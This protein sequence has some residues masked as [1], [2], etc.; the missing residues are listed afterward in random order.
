[1][2][3]IKKRFKIELDPNPEPFERSGSSIPHSKPAARERV[4]ITPKV[5]RLDICLW[6]R[7]PAGEPSALARVKSQSAC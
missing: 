7:L 6:T 1:M 5:M 4:S 3:E 2:F